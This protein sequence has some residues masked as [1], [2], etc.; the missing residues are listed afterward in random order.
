M[1]ENLHPVVAVH[2]DVKRHPQRSGWAVFLLVAT[3]LGNVLYVSHDDWILRESAERWMKDVLDSQI[4]LF[5][6]EANDQLGRGEQPD[7]FGRIEALDTMERVPTHWRP[8]QFD[9]A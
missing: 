7:L 5:L 8:G 3:E 4:G 2:S 9:A 6:V 1:L